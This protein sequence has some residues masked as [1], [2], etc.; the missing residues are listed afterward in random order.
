[1][2]Q[3]AKLYLNVDQLFHKMFFLILSMT[4]LAELGAALRCRVDDKEMTATFKIANTTAGTD[5]LWTEAMDWIA[6]WIFN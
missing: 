3:Q 1:M 5:A 6:R 2:H 4:L